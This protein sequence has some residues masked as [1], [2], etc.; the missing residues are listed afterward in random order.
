MFADDN[1]IDL[2]KACWA[3]NPK[4]RPDFEEIMQRLRQ[5]SVKNPVVNFGAQLSRVNAPVGR[6]TFVYTDV[7]DGDGLWDEVPMEMLKAMGMHNS[8]IRT[9]VENFNGY[10][11][12]F[13]G[14][15]FLLVFNQLVD[16]INWGI[17][18]QTSLMNLTWPTKLLTA[19]SY[20]LMEFELNLMV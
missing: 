17:S 13:T 2:M 4:D 1:I 20:V 11:V 8:L 15:G 3:A 16:A 7:F 18:I 14:N 10:E 6:A 19:N 9:S 5:M 12:E